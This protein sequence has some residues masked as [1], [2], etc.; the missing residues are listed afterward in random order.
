MKGDIG[1]DG[2][3]DGDIDSDIDGDIDGDADIDGDGDMLCLCF[4]ESHFLYMSSTWAPS[5]RK[6]RN[7]LPAKSFEAVCSQQKRQVNLQPMS[8]IHYQDQQ[9]VRVF[10]ERVC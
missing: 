8:A 9:Q 6:A 7:P 10:K 2:D 1:G 3:I 4:E 5:I